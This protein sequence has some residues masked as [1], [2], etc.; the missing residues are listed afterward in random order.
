M[1]ETYSHLGPRGRIDNIERDVEKERKEVIAKFKAS[2]LLA[3]SSVAR[4]GWEF[5][6]LNLGCSN[7]ERRVIERR[8]EERLSTAKVAWDA[9]KYESKI[10]MRCARSRG[11]AWQ[12]GRKQRTTRYQQSIGKGKGGEK[13]STEAVQIGS[14]GSREGL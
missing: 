11:D 7:K 6:E 1:V 5:K 3:Q 12:R 13:G 8:C 9:A 14:Q 4:L 10:C 2:A